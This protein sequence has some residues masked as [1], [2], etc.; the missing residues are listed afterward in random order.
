MVD[1]SLTKFDLAPQPTQSSPQPVGVLSPP[2]ARLTDKPTNVADS[3]PSKDPSQ[4]PVKPDNKPTLNAD[5]EIKSPEPVI[6]GGKPTV[7]ADP[8]PPEDHSDPMV[9][10][11]GLAGFILLPFQPIANKDGDNHGGEDP[12]TKTHIISLDSSDQAHRF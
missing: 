8:N 10:V 7:A 6:P 3:G 9:S 5:P 1:P 11:T 4:G 12:A 2:A